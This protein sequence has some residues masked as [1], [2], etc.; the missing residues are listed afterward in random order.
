MKDLDLT[1][2]TIVFAD[3]NKMYHDILFRLLRESYCQLIGLENG[4]DAFEY[5]K[6]GNSADILLLDI[7]MPIM[8]GLTAIKKI[9]EY[10][11]E[12]KAN[13]VPCI[14]MSSFNSAEDKKTVIDAGFDDTIS[15]PIQ[16]PLLVELLLKYKNK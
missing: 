4:K 2:V 16:R 7:Q 1:G 13:P 3:D 6:E 15:K 14:A 9:R 5:I 10:E 8:D 11:K 12:N